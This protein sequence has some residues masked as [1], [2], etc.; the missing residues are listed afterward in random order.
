MLESWVMAHQRNDHAVVSLKD[1]AMLCQS[2]GVPVLVGDLLPLAGLGSL[3][4]TGDPLQRRFQL[5]VS[6]LPLQLGH[7]LGI[8]G[9]LFL[10]LREAQAVPGGEASREVLLRSASTS[11][12]LPRGEKRVKRGK[13]MLGK[14]DYVELYRSGSGAHPLHY[15]HFRVDAPLW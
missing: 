11:I 6:F 5:S 8:A 2:N 14:E 15:A 4:T 12:F 3:G 13:N 7:L 10:P 9:C 1:Q